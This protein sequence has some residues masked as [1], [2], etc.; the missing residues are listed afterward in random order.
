MGCGVHHRLARSEKGATPSPLPPAILASTPWLAASHLPAILTLMS[1]HRAFLK[2]NLLSVGQAGGVTSNAVSTAL[3][4]EPCPVVCMYGTHYNRRC[5][6]FRGQYQVDFC[7]AVPFLP[8]LCPSL[9]AT[10]CGG[11]GFLAQY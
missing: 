2:R 4:S 8:R 9:L 5:Q 3:W 6:F 1:F 10:N 11:V 7:L